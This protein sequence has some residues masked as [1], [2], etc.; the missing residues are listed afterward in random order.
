M[1]QRSLY[2]LLNGEFA[3]GNPSLAE[4]ATNSDAVVA[5]QRFVY[6]F[7]GKNDTSNNIW[8]F[9]NHSGTSVAIDSNG[10][11]L[12]TATSGTN[13]YWAFGFNDKKTFDSEG[14]VCIWCV[15][16]QN[17]MPD[18]F[19]NGFQEWGLAT[20]IW[21]SIGS[22]VVL[23]TTSSGGTH[24]GYATDKIALSTHS[25][26]S[27][28]TVTDTGLS[29]EKRWYAWKIENKS[30]SCELSVDGQLRATNTATLMSAGAIQPFSYA[31]RGGDGDAGSIP[32]KA[33]V[34]Y[35]EAYNT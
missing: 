14:S 25:A 31:N 27:T 3:S 18:E 28:Y 15:K 1:A 32:Q 29:I 33:T 34:N 23:N 7:A 13:A 6:N 4:D 30:S 22:Y 17:E 21:G 9:D 26:E 11:T 20:S 24:G 16:P 12:T 35:C 5:K 10:M 2:D 19:A 8:T